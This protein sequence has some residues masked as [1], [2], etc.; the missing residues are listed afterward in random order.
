MSEETGRGWGRKE[1][2]GKGEILSTTPSSSPV[3]AQLALFSRFS[4]TGKPV[5]RLLNSYELQAF[6]CKDS[7][8]IKWASF[9]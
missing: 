4:P 7:K 6:D 1:G 9:D 8:K 2:R 3:C 5:D